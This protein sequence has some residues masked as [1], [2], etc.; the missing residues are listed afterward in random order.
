[1][2][3]PALVFAD[4]V[5]PSADVV[6]RVIVRTGA[7]MSIMAAARRDPEFRGRSHHQH[8]EAIPEAIAGLGIGRLSAR[9]TINAWRAASCSTCTNCDYFRQ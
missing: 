7:P 3:L 2:L 9:F 8:A 5:T 4:V 6:S 1:M